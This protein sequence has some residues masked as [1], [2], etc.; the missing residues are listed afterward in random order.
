MEPACICCK[1]LNAMREGKFDG[2]LGLIEAVLG[3]LRYVRDKHNP[4][5]P[6]FVGRPD[7]RW[8]WIISCVSYV[9]N[10]VARIEHVAGEL[11]SSGF[12]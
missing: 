6:K 9:E 8:T 12:T 2:D 1:A 4:V 11:K 10:V 7:Q 3:A 5:L